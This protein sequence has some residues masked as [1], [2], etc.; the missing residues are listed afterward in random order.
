[1]CGIAG[2]TTFGA[3]QFDQD[4][5]IRSVTQTIAHRGPDDEG[6]YRDSAVTLGHRR[7][8]IIDL[9]GGVQPMADESGRYVLAYNPN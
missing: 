3:N 2:F 4:R 9:V 5:I 8:A 1:V 6:Y 7:L